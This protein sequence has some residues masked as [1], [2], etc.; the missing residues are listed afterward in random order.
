MFGTMIT[1]INVFCYFL[2]MFQNKINSTLLPIDLCSLLLAACNTPSLRAYS[3][4]FFWCKYQVASVVSK[5]H[6]SAVNRSTLLI[7][8]LQPA[9][10]CLTDFNNQQFTDFF[11]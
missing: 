2:L 7:I 11:G 4:P 10:G 8:D 1:F 6:E 3:F 9:K 5:F